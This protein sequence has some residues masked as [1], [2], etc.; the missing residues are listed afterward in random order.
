M[1]SPLLLPGRDPKARDRVAARMLSLAERA[2][3]VDL[4]HPDLP[5]DDGEPRWRIDGAWIEFE[6]GCR[7]AR[8]PALYAVPVPGDPIIFAGLPEQAVYDAP[9]SLHAE[10]MGA[11]VRF[12]GFPTFADWRRNR[13]HL[14]LGRAL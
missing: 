5:N 6:C 14:L 11:Y 7:G 3:A 1:S 9:C 12:A 4:G 10:R 13:F 2:G 8:C